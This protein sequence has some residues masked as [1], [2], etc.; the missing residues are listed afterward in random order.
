MY[1]I[2][3]ENFVW[4]TQDGRYF[5]L[6]EMKTDYLYDAIK[7]LQKKDKYIPPIMIEEYNNRP[8]RITELSLDKP[9][10]NIKL[11][12]KIKQLEKRIEKLEESVKSFK[13]WQEL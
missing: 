4:Q 11:E 13:K 10:E 12:K 1:E 9:V 7:H 5:G 2:T 3:E 6:K 8:D